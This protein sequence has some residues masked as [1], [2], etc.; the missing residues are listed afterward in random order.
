[1]RIDGIY[2]EEGDTVW[3]KSD[4][5]GCGVITGISWHGI[6]ARRS[7]LTLDVSDSHGGTFEVIVQADDCWID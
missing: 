2:V 1:M 3:F 4:L 6:D 7:N 5:E